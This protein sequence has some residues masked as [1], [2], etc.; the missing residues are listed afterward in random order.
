M[1]V[2]VGGGRQSHLS[3]IPLGKGADVPTASDGSDITPRVR[4]PTKDWQSSPA[5]GVGKVICDCIKSHMCRYH[6]RAA[7]KSLRPNI[8][9]VS[10]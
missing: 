7:S 1:G 8:D 4:I 2:E 6:D 5:M 3:S 9:R 10:R